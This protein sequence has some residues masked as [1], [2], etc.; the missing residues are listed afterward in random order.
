MM[1]PR[2]SSGHSS[3]SEQLDLG[4]EPGALGH[5]DSLLIAYRALGRLREALLERE[6]DRELLLRESGLAIAHVEVALLDN[7]RNGHS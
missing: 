1:R 6:A 3:A 2:P 4:L 5:P 7:R